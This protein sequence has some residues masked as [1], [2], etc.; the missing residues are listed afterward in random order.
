LD[1]NGIPFKKTQF[2][3]ETKTAITETRLEEA[4]GQPLTELNGKKILEAGSGA[5][6][7]TEV[8]LKYGAVVYSFD[9]SNAIEANYDNN[10]PND[11]LTLFQA[12][13]LNIPLPDN[14]FD[15]VIALGMLQH[16]P[17]TKK[18]LKELYRVLKPGGLLTCDHYR[19]QRGMYTSLYLVWWIIIKQFKPLI[20]MKIT[21][22]LTKL[23]FPIHWALR[24]RKFL[25]MLLRRVSP[26]NFYYDRYDLPK[27]TQYEWSRLDTHDRNTDWYKRHVTRKGFETTFIELGFS[28]IDVRVIEQGCLGRGVK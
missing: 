5:G 11:Q 7:F 2:D 26:I 16:T 19:F 24:K 20:Q 15:Y 28:N 1:Y 23:F 9:F 18:S 10:M 25:Q 13:A 4:L 14:M 22:S 8:L 21:N 17:S 6:R 3:S 12:D 27:E